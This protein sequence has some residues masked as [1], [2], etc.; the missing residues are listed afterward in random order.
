M[1]AGQ[2][3][4]LGG[5]G[6]ARRLADQLANAGVA[7]TISL[8]G[9]TTSPA[10]SAG[11]VRRG[12]FGGVEG[13][14]AWLR[15]HR[16]AGVVDATHP[17]AARMSEHAAAACGQVGIPLLRLARPGWAEHP[18][19]DAWTWVDTHEQA[20]DAAAVLSAPGE[21]YDEGSCQWPPD[22]P[23][24]VPAADPA[25]GATVLLTVGRQ[26][27]SAYVPALDRHRVVARVAEARDLVVPD[28][29]LLLSDVGPFT[30][31]REERL[32]ATY[33]VGT[34]VTKDSGGAATAGKLDVAREVDAHVIVV[35]RPP[36]PPGVPSVTD[37]AAA[38]RWCLDA[39]R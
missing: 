14:A 32:F 34:L 23:R 36:P 3:L 37:V 20:A 19:A 39:A 10:R 27:T 13:L 16:P 24:R 6:E 35:R 22:A 18:D 26:S 28:G 8:A 30:R 15:R 38:V 11:E 33:R 1:A 2:V 31:E 17:F 29:W 25:Q 9:A 21:S 7:A 12:G 4:V 5:T